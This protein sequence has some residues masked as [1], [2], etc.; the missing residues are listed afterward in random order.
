MKTS[1]CRFS[2]YILHHQE[3]LGHDAKNERFN[4]M[5]M[6]PEGVC[7]VVSSLHIH[8]QEQLENHPK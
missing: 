7:G 1:L 5:K 4:N 6:Y 2:F 3:Q 8:N